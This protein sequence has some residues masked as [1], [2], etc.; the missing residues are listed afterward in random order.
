M[1]G[2]PLVYVIRHQLIP[3]EDEHDPTFGEDDINGKSKYTSHDHET[4]TR[5]PILAENCDYALEYDKLEIQGFHTD[6]KN[7]WAILR[8]L[9]LTSSMWQHVKK[10]TATQDGCQVYRT[11]HSHFFGKDKVNTMVNDILSSL[12]SKVYQ[13][14]RKNFNF[15]KYCLAHVAEHNRHA[16]LFKCDIAP[17]EESMK[18]HY[19]EEGIKDPTLDAAQ[20]AIWSTVCS[21]LTLTA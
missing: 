12:K 2:V 15:D 17:L 1:L 19:F 8:A 14:D 9:F 11:L 7:V 13:G 18:I 5:C 6:S 16:S 20:N 21:F 10:F 4:I 3:E